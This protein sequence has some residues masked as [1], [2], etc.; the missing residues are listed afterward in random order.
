ML[1]I[2][3]CVFACA[4]AVSTCLV[5]PS[6]HLDMICLWNVVL[7]RSDAVDEGAVICHDD[8]ALALIIQPPARDQRG[9]R[10][11]MLHYISSLF[12]LPPFTCRGPF[13]CRARAQHAPGFVDEVVFHGEW[14]WQ[15]DAIQGQDLRHE[16]CVRKERREHASHADCNAEIIYHCQSPLQG[17][18]KDFGTLF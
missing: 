3:E 2:D 15:V 14:P 17:V 16:T 6:P 18:L 13:P 1:L 5:V 8:E 7:W 9:E 12:L 11:H 4:A 10:R